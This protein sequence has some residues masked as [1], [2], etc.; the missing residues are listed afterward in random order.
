M[1]KITDYFK[2]QD[3]AKFIGVTENT[4]LS[5]SERDGSYKK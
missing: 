1:A 5:T 2:I 3:A 4:L